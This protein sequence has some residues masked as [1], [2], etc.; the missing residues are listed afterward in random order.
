MLYWFN[1]ITCEKRS[2]LFEDEAYVTE[3][4]FVWNFFS[5]IS[6]SGFL[7]AYLMK[8]PYILITSPPFFLKFC[9]ISPPKALIFPCS[10]SGMCHYAKCNVLMCYFAWSYYGLKLD[11]CSHLMV[12][13]APCY[14][15]Y[16]KW[17]HIYSG[18]DTD[19][20]FRWYSDLISRTETNTDRTHRTNRLKH[21]H[22]Y[23]L[24]LFVTCTPRG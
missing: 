20:S 9:P 17:H 19:N 21:S 4:Y 18:F 12:L 23:I 22:K 1:K 14:V 6:A 24:T 7:T 15:L 13:A 3:R 16:P 5:S 8:S 10:F 2:C 11:E